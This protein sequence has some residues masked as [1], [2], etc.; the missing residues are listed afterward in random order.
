MRS[1]FIIAPALVVVAA[2]TL[3][4]LQSTAGA[5][6]AATPTKAGPVPVYLMGAAHV[7]GFN[8]TQWRTSLEV[9]NFGGVGRSY[10][11]DF[12]H[13]GQSNL[14]PEAVE[15]TLAPGLCANYPDAV[16]S[17]FGL[18]EA[19]GTIRLVADGDGVVTV[20][21]TYNDTPDG[22]YGTA[23]GAIPV[24]EAVVE[25]A[26]TVL[27]HLA[28]SASDD[29]GY[30]TNLDL[31]N[32]TDIEVE[33]EVA[34]YG[35]TGD[36][37]GTR[38]TTLLP[39]EYNQ[40]M[41]VFRQVTSNDV[42]DGYAV[43]R[44]TTAGGALMAAASLVDNRTGDTTTITGSWVPTSERWLE[45]ENMGAA[46]NSAGDDWYPV[47][48]PDGSYMVFVSEGYGGYGFGDLY[49]SRLVGGV[50]QHAENMGPNVNTSDFETA[51]FLSR[52]GRTLYFSTNFNSHNGN[53]DIWSCPMVDGVAGPRTR[54]PA[55]I[56]G[57]THDCCPVV[58]R[59]GTTMYLCSDRPGGS[60]DL[61]VWV[62]QR[63]GGEWQPPVN[64]GAIVNSSQID[65]PRWLS[66]DGSNLIVASN[67]HGRI[68]GA[69]LWSVVRSGAEWLAPVNLGSPINSRSDEWGPGFVGNDGGISGRMYF[70][71]GRPGGHGGWDIWYSDLGSPVVGEGASPG[72]VTVRIPAATAVAKRTEAASTAE[73]APVGR[74]CCSS[75][76]S[77]R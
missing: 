4:H 7:P 25:G 17:V 63:V 64:L 41:R 23:L 1:E 29:V 56:N 5:S 58:S 55:P 73:P 24:D 18:D 34:L 31:L 37:Y 11:L 77:E 36:H 52:D 21:R 22:T 9:C 66:D 39:F 46:I 35:S 74:G 70:G 44:T 40:M 72:S 45:P 62:A 26:S 28:Q 59:D 43:V 61:D 20:A 12:L 47:L 60:G 10:E 3:V 65:C 6:P 48:A 33:V 49:I 51:P 8:D 30:R 53:L 42:D 50:W 19:V 38:T 67:R 68:G 75:K 27:V 69:D 32:V 57:S 54:L 13:R 76:T 2:G 16:A 14:E 15:L 71:S